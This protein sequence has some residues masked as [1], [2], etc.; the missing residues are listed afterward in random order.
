MGSDIGEWFLIDDHLVDDADLVG[1]SQLGD[2]KLLLLTIGEEL[3]SLSR[4]IRL[5]QFLLVP[6]LGTIELLLEILLPDAVCIN[7]IIS[8]RLHLDSRFKNFLPEASGDDTKVNKLILTKS[9]LLDV[10]DVAFMI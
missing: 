2:G 8:C 1:R 9:L 3:L 10:I 5:G 4:C 6:V 7:Q